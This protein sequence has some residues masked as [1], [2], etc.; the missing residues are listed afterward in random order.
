MPSRFSTPNREAS[1]ALAALIFVR[2]AIE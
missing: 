2:R 1:D